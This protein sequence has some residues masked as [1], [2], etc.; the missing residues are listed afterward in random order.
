MVSLG[1]PDL[2]MKIA[3]LRAKCQVKGINL[4]DQLIDYIAETCNG[5]ARELEGVLISILPLAR[6]SQ[7]KIS[8]EAVRAHIEAGGVKSSQNPT[9]QKIIQAVCSYFRMKPEDLTSPSRKSSLV[10]P[11]QILMYLMR[12][13]LDLPLEQIGQFIGGRDHSTVIY[14]IEKIEKEISQNQ[15]RRDD[16]FRIKSF[17]NN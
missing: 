3:I 14:G 2:E 7:D 4:D 17:I 13:E 10:L 1:P 8:I 12:K 16:L 6:F 9:P 15:I 11:R 5:G